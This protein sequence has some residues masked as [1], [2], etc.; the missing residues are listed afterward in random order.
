[1]YYKVELGNKQD[2]SN[3]KVNVDHGYVSINA[4]LQNKSNNSYSASTVSERFPVPAGVDPN[5]ARI[6]KQG[7]AIVIRFNKV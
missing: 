4:K 1:M 3:V 2:L 7:D 5:S 6:T